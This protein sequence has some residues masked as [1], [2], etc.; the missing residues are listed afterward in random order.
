MIIAVSGSVGTGKTTLAKKLAK[1]LNHDYVDVT[2]MIMDS[3]LPEG[4]DKKRQCYIIDTKKL[5]S[6]LLLL[7]QKNKNLVIDSHL[8]HYLPAKYVDRCIITKCELK[9][10]SQRLK[11]RG[12]PKAKIKDN[13]EAEIFDVCYEEAKALGHNVSVVDTAKRYDIKK[14]IRQ[15][16]LK[17]LK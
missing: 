6:A 3:K 1:Q 7:I 9:K 8:S 17:R 5:N 14:I 13:L 16:K 11:K 12:Y 4:Y 10:L 15:L 2:A